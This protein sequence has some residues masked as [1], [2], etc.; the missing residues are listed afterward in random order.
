MIKFI[1][2]LVISVF[3]IVIF[4]ASNTKNN[5]QLPDLELYVKK[6]LNI[7]LSQ[8]ESSLK[9]D[10]L[11]SE[12][13]I[14]HLSAIVN[15]YEPKGLNREK[16]NINVIVEDF[17]NAN[18]N[19][20]ENFKYFN[21]QLI[22]DSIKININDINITNLK[23]AIR[24]EKRFNIDIAEL[25]VQFKSNNI[26]YRFEIGNAYLVNN[27]WKFGYLSRLIDYEKARKGRY[28]EE[29]ASDVEVEEAAVAADTAVAV[30]EEPAYEE[31]AVK[32]SPKK[33]PSKKKP[34][35]KPKSVIKKSN[36]KK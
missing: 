17:R 7:F 16:R 14:Q 24:K 6:M 21:K 30:M 32:S 23:Y 27:Q 4:S 8:N 11:L 19:I 13:D 33:V 26:E 15:S 10:I 28:R 9:Q 22:S 3:V 35:V 18:L 5:T 2:T 29:E 34:V 31:P 36:V 1:K 25:E 20:I 12:T